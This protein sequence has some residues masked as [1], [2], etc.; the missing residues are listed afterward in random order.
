QPIVGGELRRALLLTSSNRKKAITILDAALKRDPENRELRLL[1]AQTLIESN[2]RDQGMALLKELVNEPSTYPP[3]VFN[4]AKLLRISKKEE[5]KKSA[6]ELF[7][8]YVALEPND[9]RGHDWL[10]FAY[11]D[12]QEF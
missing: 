2:D 9:P 12:A 7:N 5:E 1:K 10:A 8:K 4:L 3:A 11:V 6:S